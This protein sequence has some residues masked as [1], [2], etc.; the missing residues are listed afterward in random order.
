MGN[1]IF[2]FFCCWLKRSKKSFYNRNMDLLISKLL[3]K[4]I[5]DLSICVVS[6]RPLPK[7]K[8]WFQKQFLNE[9]VQISIINIFL[10]RFDQQQKKLKIGFTIVFSNLGRK[11]LGFFFPC[12]SANFS[13]NALY[14]PNKKPWGAP[15]F[16]FWLC[17]FIRIGYL[18]VFM[19]LGQK[20]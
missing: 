6:V 2:K 5:L 7:V 12:Q 15:N 13:P 9:K 14:L 1:P 11:G 16:W 19:D 20:N 3:S 8:N 4:S 10:V 17:P 18:K